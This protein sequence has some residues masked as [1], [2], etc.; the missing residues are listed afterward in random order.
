VTARFSRLR[1]PVNAPFEK[2]RFGCS[3]RQIDDLAEKGLRQQT[4]P[5]PRIYKEIFPVTQDSRFGGN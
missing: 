1:D 5:L 4:G 2:H 3:A